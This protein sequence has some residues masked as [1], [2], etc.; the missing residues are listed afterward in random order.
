[1]I[2]I[3]LATDLD[4]GADEFVNG[5]AWRV[6]LVCTSPASDPSDH[7]LLPDECLALALRLGQLQIDLDISGCIPLETA[8]LPRLPWSDGESS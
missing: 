6:R 1:M 2:T 8:W 4:A 5:P 3:D 7:L